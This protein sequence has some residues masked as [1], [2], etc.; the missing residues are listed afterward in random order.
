M[1][2]LDFSLCKKILCCHL[3]PQRSRWETEVAEIVLALGTV[4]SGSNTGL[5]WALKM[6]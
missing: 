2:D 6:S 3:H 1:D 4:F 5:M